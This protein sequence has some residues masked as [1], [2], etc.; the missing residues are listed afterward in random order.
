VIFGHLRQRCKEFLAKILPVFATIIAQWVASEKKKAEKI[1]ELVEL[2]LKKCDRYF[3]NDRVDQVLELVQTYVQDP[4]LTETC[5]SILNTLLE[6]GK[7]QLK[8]K[9]AV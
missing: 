3:P 2:L 5:L 4:Q 9:V 7:N 1:F 8:S 6:V